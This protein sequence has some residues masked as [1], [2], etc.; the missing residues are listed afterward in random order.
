[1]GRKKNRSRVA[2]LLAMAN[3]AISAIVVAVT[4]QDA[5]A[6]TC[7]NFA[8]DCLTPFTSPSGVGCT[9][10]ST[11]STVNLNYSGFLV[12]TVNLIYSPSPCRS[13][14]TLM[15]QV[16]SPTSCQTYSWTN[17]TS[18]YTAGDTYG[19]SPE[20]N[21]QA[22]QNNYWVQSYQLYDANMQSR[23]WGSYYPPAGC[24][25]TT[26]YAYTNTGLY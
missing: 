23:G 21:F 18:P 15:D 25:A 13:I 3:L 1:M 6:S 5:S 12:G 20:S 16:V 24:A 4:A 19:L 2:A 10:W 8:S 26:G 17:R 9:S 22:Y 7:G 14:A 11:V